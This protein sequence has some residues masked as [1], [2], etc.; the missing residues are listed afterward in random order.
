MILPESRRKKEAAVN[1]GSTTTCGA[2]HLATRKYLIPLESDHLIRE[3][4]QSLS[5]EMRDRTVF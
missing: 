1:Q 5:E 2:A 4:D 3:P